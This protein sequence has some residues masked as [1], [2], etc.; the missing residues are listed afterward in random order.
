VCESNF[1]KPSSS[2]G[3]RLSLRQNF[4][5]LQ[6]SVIRQNPAFVKERL[7]IKHF[8]EVGLVDEIL[9][10][11]ETR[12]KLTFDFDETKAKINSTSKEIGVLM[13]KGQREEADAKKR[14]VETFKNALAPIQQQLEETE[15][16]LQQALVQLPNL[17]S[18]KVPPGNCR[19]KKARCIM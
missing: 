11:D 7:A 13:G 5:M 2:I 12:K 14:S 1:F 4:F 6:V 17:P 19:T 3:A 10:L 8:K 9:A 18:E 15:K 16:K